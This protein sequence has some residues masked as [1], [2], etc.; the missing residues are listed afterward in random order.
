MNAIYTTA[1]LLLLISFSSFSKDQM[2]TDKNKEAIRNFYGNILNKRK[3]EQLD[4][5]ISKDY[6]N[7]QGDKGVAGFQKQI[8]ELLKA[9][10]DAQWTLTAIVA[11]GDK[12]FVKQSMKGTHTGE[13]QHI[14]PT[15]K[16]ITSEGTV[17]Y[18]FRDGKIINHETQ[19]DR[20]AFLQQLGLIPVDLSTLKTRQ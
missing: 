3:F 15:N 16:V 8:P 19:T 4:S 10:P 11:E 9:F 5:L 14:P 18:E 7:R 1:C 17:L 2:N 13:F 20:L 6:V 12:V